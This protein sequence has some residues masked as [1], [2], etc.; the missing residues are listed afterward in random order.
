MFL[1][2]QGFPPL[3]QVHTGNLFVGVDETGKEVCRL[4]GYENTLLGHVTNQNVFTYQKYDDS[5]DLRMLGKFC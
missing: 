5:I 3:G 1:Y 4:G 2:E